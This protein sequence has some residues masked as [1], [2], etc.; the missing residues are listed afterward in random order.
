MITISNITDQVRPSIHPIENHK[1]GIT[2]S[3]TGM[4]KRSIYLYN[5]N[6]NNLN[7]YIKE[8]H[9]CKKSLSSLMKKKRMFDKQFSFVKNDFYENYFLMLFINFL[10]SSQAISFDP[11]QTAKANATAAAPRSNVKA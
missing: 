6:I 8:S 5:Y 7:N 4:T 9:F 11:S 10:T 1:R 2:M 3:K